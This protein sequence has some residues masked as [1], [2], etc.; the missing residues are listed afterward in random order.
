MKPLLLQLP[1]GRNLG[2]WV[3]EMLDNTE[4][5]FLEGDIPRKEEFRVHIRYYGEN[6]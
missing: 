2:Y 5:R 6:V 3:I 4:S 1:S